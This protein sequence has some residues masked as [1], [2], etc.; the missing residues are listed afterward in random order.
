MSGKLPL[1]LGIGAAALI[2]LY[3]FNKKK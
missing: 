3:F 2:G 1:I